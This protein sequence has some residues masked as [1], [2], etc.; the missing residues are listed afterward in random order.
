MTDQSEAGAAA[1]VGGD[2]PAVAGAAPEGKAAAGAIGG[3]STGA[4]KLG[5]MLFRGDLALA[6]GVVSIL[7]V[8]ILPMP[9]W[10]L[11]MA[12]AMSMTFSVLI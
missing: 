8:L 12:L 3:G 7:V 9:P 1:P 5:A 11:D 2:P 10:A 6:F 4:G